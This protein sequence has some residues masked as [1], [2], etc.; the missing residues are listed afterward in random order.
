[1]DFR[2][3]GPLEAL[4][5]SRAVALGGHRRRAVFAA[6]LLHRGE[7]LSSERLIDELWGDSAPPN[8]VKTL[9]AHVSRLRKELPDGVLVTRG[10]G[11]E[12]QIDPDEL[13]AH[14]FER[15][16]EQGRGELAADRPGPALEAL[17]GA[18]S[19]WRGA[20]LAD[21][22]YEPFAQA[23]IAR[24]EDL[25]VAAS[26]QTIEARLALG[27]HAEVIAE[28]ERLVDE[29]PYREGLRAQLMLALYRAD[30]QADALQAYQ[31]ARRVL[32]EELGIEPGERLR[33]LEAAVLAHDPALSLREPERAPEPP[34]QPKPEVPDSELPTGVVT[35]LMTDIERSSALWEADADAMAA[36]LA[37]HDELIARCAEAHDGRLL[38]TKG[39]GDSTVTVFPRASDALDCAAALRESLAAVTWHGDLDLRVRAALHTG[40]AHERGGD[41]F[42]PALNRTARIRGMADGGTTLLSQ[43]TRELVHDRLPA[44]T[45]LVDLGTHELR[46]LS[47]PERVFELRA[48]G[49]SVRVLPPRETRKTVTALLACLEDGS[50]QEVDAEARRRDSAQA[51]AAARTVLE[52]H[53]GTVEEYPGDALMAIFGVPLLHE[54]DALRAVRAAV[55]LRRMLPRR[56]RIGVATDEV[57]AER[58]PGRAPFATGDAIN[59]A[60]RLQEAAEVDEI[61]VDVATCR[62]ARESVALDPGADGTYRVASLRSGEVRSHGFSSPLVGRDQQLGTLETT[63]DAAVTGRGCHLVTVL[64]AAGVGKSRLVEELATRLGDRATVLRGRCLPYGDGITYWPLNEVVRDLAGDAGGG[65]PA[66]V[67]DALAAELSGEPR[68]EEVP[69]VLAEAAGLGEASGLAEEKIFWAARRLFEVL[70]ERRPLVVVLDDLQWAEATFLDLVEHVADLARGVPLLLLCLARPE[71]LDSRRGW[72]GGKLNATSILLEPLP[73]AE[74]RELVNNLVDALSPDASERIAAACEG[75]P[76]F[77]EE[78]LA[79]LIEDGLLE[80]G[81]AGWALA[82]VQ[83]TLPVPPT[84]QALLGARIDRL[85]EDERTLLTHVSVEGTL[86][87]RESMRELAP[88][89]LRPVVERC[90]SELVRR[91]LIRPER[92]ALG[93]DDAFRFRH[94][95]VRDAAYRSLPKA[96]RAELHERFGGW[97]EEA[98]PARAG[99]F[100]EI[101]GYHLEQAWRFRTDLGATPEDTAAVASRAAE[102]LEA[103]GRRAQRRSDHRA[104]AS[105]LERAAVLMPADGARRTALLPDLGAALIEAGRLPDAERVLSE[106]VSAGRAAGDVLALSHA[107]VQQQML[108]IRRGAPSAAAEASAV[109]DDVLP[110]FRAAGDE[111][112]QCSA[113]RLR[114]WHRWLVGCT[115]D[116]AAAWEQAAEHARAAG[117]EHERTDLLAWIASSLFFGPTPVAAAIERCEEIRVEVAGNLVATAA[118]LQPLAGLHAMEGRVDEARAL[119]AAAR[120]AFEELGLTL[121]S[122]VSHHAAMVELLAGDPAAAE[123][124]LRKG[125]AALEQMGER[126]VLSTTAAFLG[127]ALLAQGRDEEAG[128]FAEQSAELAPDDDVLSQ[129]MWRG[130]LASAL[131]A[132]GDLVEAERLAREA[133]GHAERTDYANQIAEA[134][135]VLGTVLARRGEPERAH[136]ELSK[137]L[138]LYE[139]KGNAVAAEQVRADLAPLLQV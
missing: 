64:G 113:L 129:A 39:E 103:A 91:D 42:G 44:G 119:I 48:L 132:S 98:H 65:S 56:A 117:L 120:S 124:S 3:L 125:H 81:E 115:E 8:S 74:S 136:A 118:V 2:I 102:R 85:P 58:E 30:R 109:V 100:E 66:A 88:S 104:A 11:Y 83:G 5:G 32:V 131:A 122:A 33:E 116:A 37:L 82:G 133:V 127:Q 95:L 14:R 7:T 114:G 1:M 135:F 16:L 40:E 15:L 23:E 60:K 84:I 18:L 19:L 26:E 28:L 53:G 6:L 52:R 25:R 99:E 128:R 38:K 54:D 89:A 31:D 76:L 78:L 10:H 57:I 4:D 92:A 130:V 139:R 123:R 22:A 121:E 69:D 41:Y 126:A 34:P 62:L 94:I 79:M 137:A 70:A 71:L 96:T 55:E 35:F 75:H 29:H 80:R 112:G 72:A 111:Q 17:E 21:L 105:L 138:E 49:E 68:A 45:E 12:L 47:R 13:D 108:G 67:R 73:P 87:H 134:H 97:L 110:V 93:D 20:P 101:V 77:A 61:A 36:S 27:R 106:A 107:L 9:Q 63:F 90:L 51:L 50:D 24:L 86:F 59:A 43:A 46:D